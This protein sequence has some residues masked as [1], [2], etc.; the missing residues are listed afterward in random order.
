MIV[1]LCFGRNFID[2]MAGR[3]RWHIPTSKVFNLEV[4]QL[5]LNIL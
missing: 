5:W 1:E 4:F 3:A 2:S